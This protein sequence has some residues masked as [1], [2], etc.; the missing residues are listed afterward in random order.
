LIADFSS[1]ECDVIKNCSKINIY[2][3]IVLTI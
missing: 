3:L 2:V 1:Q